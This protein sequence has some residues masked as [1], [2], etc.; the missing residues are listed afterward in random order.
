MNE[1]QIEIFILQILLNLGHIIL[2]HKQNCNS[3]IAIAIAYVVATVITRV[4][5]KARTRVMT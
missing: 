2:R 3:A 1:L 4:G 5:A